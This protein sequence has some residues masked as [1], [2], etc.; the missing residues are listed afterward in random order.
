MNAVPTPGHEG[1]DVVDPHDDFGVAKA[2]GAVIGR[3][4]VR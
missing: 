1:E 4:V 3:L 2:L